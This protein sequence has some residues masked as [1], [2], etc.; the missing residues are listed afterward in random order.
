MV[1]KKKMAKG[2]EQGAWSREIGAKGE[3]TPLAGG[4][5]LVPR[6]AVLEAGGKMGKR[7]RA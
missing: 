1:Y 5:R 3:G 2:R 7:Q 6:H 4:W